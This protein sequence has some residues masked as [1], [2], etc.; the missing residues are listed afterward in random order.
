M[1]LSFTLPEI[2]IVAQKL[3]DQASTTVIRIDG[4]MGAGKTT[5]IATIVKLLGVNEGASSPTF[6]LVNSYEGKDKTFYH[7]D[8]YRLN[9]PDEALDIGLEEYLE[10][11]NLCLLEWAEKVIPHLPLEYDHFIIVV[12]SDESRILKKLKH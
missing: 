7:F 2:E 11:G 4:E 5:L 12:Q 9:H 8:F 1:Q 3:L 10:S 6:S